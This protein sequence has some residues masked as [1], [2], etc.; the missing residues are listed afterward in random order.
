V[1][2]HGKLAHTDGL[3]VA[4]RP[5]RAGHFGSIS[6]VSALGTL[7]GETRM[8][9]ASNGMV[10]VI[11]TQPTEFTDPAGDAWAMIRLKGKRFSRPQLLSGGCAVV[12]P[13][14]VA[15]PGGMVTAAWVD[16]C[17]QPQLSGA[18]SA[19][20]APFGP[21]EPI[22]DA[23]PNANEF[24]FLDLASMGSG[25]AVAVFSPDAQASVREP[26]GPFGA[27]ELIANSPAATTPRVAA[28]GRLAIAG[29]QGAGGFYYST[30]TG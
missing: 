30:L 1:V 16:A 2:V 19:N 8:A 10:A 7:V 25:T 6:H 27:P 18:A 12:S 28:A 22:Y 17:G 11:W 23:G 9:V 24:G 13:R 20:G 5:A 14:I 15:S 3:W 26:G 29:W 4:E 21:G